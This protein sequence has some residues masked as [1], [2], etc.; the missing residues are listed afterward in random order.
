MGF[1]IGSFSLSSVYF[2]DVSS[3]KT[4]SLARYPFVQGDFPTQW[5]FSD[6]FPQHPGLG[7]PLGQR[8]WIGPVV[9]IGALVFLLALQVLF[10][11]ER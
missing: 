1:R 7:D 4:H 9:V 10:G 5:T 3:I 8:K 11:F 2:T 6:I